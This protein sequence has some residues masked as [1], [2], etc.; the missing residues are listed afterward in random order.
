MLSKHVVILLSH[1]WTL[2]FFCT[3]RMGKLAWVI[4]PKWHVSWMYRCVGGKVWVNSICRPP[5]NKIYMIYSSTID[6]HP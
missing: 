4:V 6:M 3:G 1:H 5:P 2:F